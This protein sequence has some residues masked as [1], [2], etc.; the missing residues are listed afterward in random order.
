[1]RGGTAEP[2]AVAFGR[3]FARA[4]VAAVRGAVAFETL[5]FVPGVAAD[6]ATDFGGDPLGGVF[7]RLSLR[8]TGRERGRLVSTSRSE[9]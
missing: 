8:R 5:F 9:S 4:V 2:G 7:A 1:M 3:G 6:R